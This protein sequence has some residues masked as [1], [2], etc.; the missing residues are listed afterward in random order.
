MITEQYHA[1]PVTVSC[2][3]RAIVFFFSMSL[4]ASPLLAAS[5]LNWFVS[6]KGSDKPANY[7]MV[8][9]AAEV[10]TNYL[11]RV[12]GQTVSLGA[13]ETSNAK[14]TFLIT[15]AS[16][17]PAE[18]VKRLDGKRRDAFIIKY[19]CNLDG[20]N[21]CLL[22]S[23]DVYGADFA[24]YW[25]LNKFLD[26]NWVGPGADGEI[27]S[28]KPDWKM[29]DSIDVLENPDLEMRFWN[30][31]DFNCRP[32]LAGSLRMSFH[33][34][35][36]GIFSPEKYGDQPELYPLVE[37]KRYVPPKGGVHS[38]GWQPC[39]SSPK[40]VEIA[41]QSVLDSLKNDP[42]RMTA[43]LSV[44]DGAGNYCTCD[45]CR[46]QDSKIAFASTSKRPNLSDR[47]IRFYNQVIDKAMAVNPNAYIAVLGY[48][49]V[50]DPPVEVK[51]HPHTVVFQSGTVN[52]EWTKA[53]ALP[54]LYQWIY[55]DGYQMVRFYPH[56][57]ADLIR[58][59]KAQNGIG[60]YA[61]P[62]GAWAGGGPKL[63]VLS[64]L[65]WNA[66][67]D[68]DALTD[69]YVR[70]AFG[71][72]AAPAMRAYLDKWEEIYERGPKESRPHTIIGWRQSNQFNNL[73]FDDM[74]KLDAAIAKAKAAK[75]TDAQRK[76]LGYF[77]TYYEWIRISM[78]QA[79]LA[80]QFSDLLW[81]TAHAEDDV[82]A[83]AAASAGLT[84]KFNQMWRDTISTDKTGWLFSKDGGTPEKMWE[85]Y[86]D[87][88][89]N[90]IDSTYATSLDRLLNYIAVRQR[91][92]LDTG[93]LV[94]HWQ[95]QAK[96]Y[97]SLAEPIEAMLNNLQGK[98]SANLVANPGFEKGTPGNPPKL[99]GWQTYQEFGGVRE[100]PHHYTWR[101]GEGRK[102]G[103][104]V[105]IHEGLYQEIRT[106]V[107]LDKG[108]YRYSYWYK[109]V[110]RE[111][112][113]RLWFCLDRGKE[114][115][116]D[117]VSFMVVD[118]PPTDG[119]WKQI[120]RIFKVNEPGKY[121]F[122]PTA[123]GQEE[124]TSTWYDDVEIV[125]LR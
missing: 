56:L 51:V 72:D 81:I 39:T 4:F 49:P 85:V 110:N 117:L 9:P 6:Y 28:S 123:N 52:P 48:G 98:V 8:K 3:L 19:P 104:A 17:A 44:N 20:K 105:G 33:H 35:L 101:D 94:A 103:K 90:D 74:A 25:F 14:V 47:F 116:Q 63:Y 36:G 66:N 57:E 96:K 78:E 76:R 2:A 29:P 54:A 43:S 73:T 84:D 124:G 111:K 22:V 106:F 32:W 82:L 67:S 77:A 112:P 26:V 61:E 92:S 114:G 68:V 75:L 69:R 12:L 40:A 16:R 59:L 71:D 10:L 95:A 34:A 55:Q 5:D 46:A 27:V 97:P 122:Q 23:H 108:T 53:G 120:T 115:K 24:A 70:L 13:L 121:V 100:V 89:R 86:M 62:Y 93:K 45:A 42:A 102:G 65:L 118:E 7:D 18:I 1:R 79:L 107:N 38:A 15:D 58:Q 80:R 99:D 37:G 31:P 109:T 50:K 88:M 64:H 11:S 21:V 87:A 119:E 60:Y 30:T 83:R 91:G 113:L 41:T 125:K